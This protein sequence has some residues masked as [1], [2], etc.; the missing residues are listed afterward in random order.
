MGDLVEEAGRLLREAGIDTFRL[1]SA[2]LVEHVT[3]RS[4]AAQLARPESGVPDEAVLALR[5]LAARRAGREPLQYVLGAAVFRGRTFTVSPAVL[6]PRPETETLVEVALEGLGDRRRVLDVGTG[7]GCIA[8]TIA[9]ERPDCEVSACDLSDAA[10]DVAR[11]NADRMGA[12]VRFFG[13]DALSSGF[14]LEA[15][16]PYDLVVSNPPYIPHPDAPGLQ[17]EVVG[18]EPHLALFSGSDPLRFHRAFARAAVDGLVSPGGC[19]LCELHDG[20]GPEAARDWKAAGLAGIRVLPDVSGR[21]RFVCGRV[22]L[23]E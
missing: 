17:P 22:P 3:G 12:R 7:S 18:H 20:T 9:L 11:T 6:I 2:W 4:R 23:K 10:L 16:G 1:E 14:A 13:S 21:E 8:V 15:G 5:A 19:L